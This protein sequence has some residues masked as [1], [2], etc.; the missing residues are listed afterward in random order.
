MTAQNFWQAAVLLLTALSLQGCL[1][2]AVIDVAAET[3]EAGVGITGAVAGGV[4]DV[5]TPNGDDDDD[6]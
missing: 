2:G 1:V 6:D 5:V 4:V 3:V